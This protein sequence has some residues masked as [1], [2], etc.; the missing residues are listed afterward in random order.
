MQLKEIHSYSPSKFAYHLCQQP[1]V[2]AAHPSSHYLA[3]ATRGNEIAFFNRRTGR[4][5][6]I[7]TSKHGIALLLFTENYL[8]AVER[9]TPEVIVFSIKSITS[10]IQ[11]RR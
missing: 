8:L 4:T 11:L 6:I 10:L 7:F 9:T 1:L 3:F 2:V 5:S